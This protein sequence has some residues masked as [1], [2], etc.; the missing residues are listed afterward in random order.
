MDPKAKEVPP[1]SLIGKYIKRAFPAKHP[2]TGKDMVEHMWV[3]VTAYKGGR[4]HGTVN[5]D[6]I[7][8]CDWQDG[9]PVEFDPSSIELIYGGE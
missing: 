5:N 8:L 3:L 4:L 6:P 2:L 1:R 7:L 9:S